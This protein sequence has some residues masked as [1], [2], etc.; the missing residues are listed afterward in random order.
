MD[1]GFKMYVDNLVSAKMA[2]IN[3]SIAKTVGVAKTGTKEVAD[4]FQIMGDRMTDTFKNLKGLLLS[5]LGIT[6]FFEGWQFI[7]NSKVAFEGLEKAIARVDTVLKST[8]FAAGFSSEDI[9]NQSKELSNGIT[10]KRDEILDAQ[11]MLLSFHDIKGNTFKETTS[12]VADFATFYKE[13]MTEAAMQV[14]KAV[15]NPLKG[16]ARLVRMGVEFDP[17]QQKHIKNYMQQGNL[18]AAQAVILKELNTEFGGQAKAFAL[19]DAGK[20]QVASKQWEELQFKLGEIIS[21]VEVSLIPS[22]TKMVNVIKDAFNSSAIQFFII[23][24][25]DLI[26]WALKL[27][28]IW[29]GYKIVM[30]GVYKVQKLVAFGEALFTKELIT[31][32][33]A[34]AGNKFAV[35]G[36]AQYM[37]STTVAIGGTSAAMEALNAA[38]ASTAFGVLIVGLGLVIESFFQLN[39]EANDFIDKLTGI[40]EIRDLYQQNTT[41]YRDLEDRVSTS[42]DLDKKGHSALIG[43]MISGQ[44]TMIESMQNKVI[45]KLYASKKAYEDAFKIVGYTQA[46]LNPKT[47]GILKASRPIYAQDDVTK[48]EGLRA[49]YEEEYNNK[50]FLGAQ[51]KNLGDQIK[52]FSKHY[53]PLSATYTGSG[54]KDDATH[55]SNLSGASGGLGQAKIIKIE[56]NGPFQQNNGVKESQ[57][58]ADKAIEKMTEMINSFS[59]SVNSI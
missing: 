47:G 30:A 17:I 43:D 50:K 26:S 20:I 10:A 31:N 53:K 52:G 27:L 46:E 13:N 8:K 59:D 1:Y 42:S 9:Q 12:A 19:T 51:I 28:P 4:H 11:G 23:H 29:F 2:E 3:G 38:I 48:R 54:L 34:V 6:A 39:Q 56:F 36:F 5:G 55:T 21:R 41:T 44:K 24:I 18:L 35:L 45:P 15:N 37:E 22:F 40:G 32:T 57:N 25:K 7:E 58:E 16:M 49:A 14:G 33:G